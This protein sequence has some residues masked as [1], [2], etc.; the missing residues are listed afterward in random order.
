VGQVKNYR[1]TVPVQAIREIHGI[2]AAENRKAIFFTSGR[3]T[4]AAVDFAES[5]D[6]PLITYN[7]LSSDFKGAN[8]PGRMFL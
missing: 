8:G 5:V 7:A 6:M 3:Y 4:K 1:G 2:A